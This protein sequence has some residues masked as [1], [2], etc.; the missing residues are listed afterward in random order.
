MS[1]S[2]KHSQALFVVGALGIVLGAL[3]WSRTS[4]GGAHPGVLPE[5][6]IS[7]VQGSSSRGSGAQLNVPKQREALAGDSTASELSSLPLG[8]SSENAVQMRWV[9]G[10]VVDTAGARIAGVPL[11]VWA[12]DEVLA[13]TVSSSAG[14]FSLEVVE[15]AYVTVDVAGENYVAVLKGATRASG[16]I[17][18]E[19]VIVAS[20]AIE[21]SGSVVNGEGVAVDEAQV[22][23]VLPSSFRGRF[24]L[25]LGDSIAENWSQKTSSDGTFCMERVPSLP[26]A[27][28]ITERTGYMAHKM[29]A[30]T[31]TQLDLRI[32]LEPATNADGVL[33]GRVLKL[34]GEPAPG[35]LVAIGPATDVADQ[36]GGFQLELELSKGDTLLAVLAGYQP[37]RLNR[38][39]SQVAP[40]GWPSQVEL[41]LGGPALKMSGAVEF[42]DGSPVAGAR[43]S[44]VDPGYFGWVEQGLGDRR[45]FNHATVETLAGSNPKADP[46]GAIHADESGRFV[47]GG[48]AP[49]AYQLLAV[50]PKSLAATESRSLQAGSE[51]ITLVVSRPEV[52]RVAGVVRGWDGEPLEGAFVLPQRTITQRAEGKSDMQEMA[53]GAYQLTDESGSF[54]FEELAKVGVQLLVSG[55]PVGL[56]SLTIDLSEA[57]GPLTELDLTLA[58]WC[59]LQVVVQQASAASFRVF[60]ALGEPLSIES[61]RGQATLL[62]ERAPLED[63]R[64]EVVTVSE[65]ACELRVY[66]PEG[67]ELVRQPLSLIR[68][69]VNRLEL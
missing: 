19:V 42:E 11:V 39:T 1:Q 7:S 64:S 66:G 37:A 23:L 57:P 38:D 9:W 33:V 58:G 13:R 67:E 10:R 32:V 36:D 56:E 40:K 12:G 18:E 47:I 63:G 14:E 49:R 2:M 31:E 25:D 35:A 69:E 60:D 24:D 44:L 68:A 20:R 54:N 53:L 29:Q 16:A 65:R 30:P 43:V 5:T 45:F 52:S 15:G 3:V 62:L 48:L 6:A 4:G 55:E 41:V 22:S 8:D 34:S 61:E 21:L 27:A 51:S 46:Y 28:L 26:D 59:K 17:D 50:D